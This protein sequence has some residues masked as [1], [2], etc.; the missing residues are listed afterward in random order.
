MKF[1][2]TLHC[3]RLAIV[4]LLIISFKSHAQNVDTDPGAYMTAISNAEMNMNKSYLTYMSAVA[5]SGRA[6]KVEKMRQQTLQS[7]QDCKYKISDLP[8]F[9]GDNSLRKISINYV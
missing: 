2:S 7:I 8:Y 6:K 5:H 4:F 3:Q 1:K 9:K